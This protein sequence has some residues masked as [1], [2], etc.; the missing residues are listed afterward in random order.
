[1]LMIRI[2]RFPSY[3]AIEWILETGLK[4]EM[5]A[6]ACK[7][8]GR[9]AIEWILETG[10][11][12]IENFDANT[13]DDELQLSESWKRDWN[14][15]QRLRLFLVQWLQLSESWKRDWN[16]SLF[17]S[18]GVPCHVAIEWI[19]ETGLKRAGGLLIGGGGGA[20]QLSESWKRDWN[21]KKKNIQPEPDPLQLSES[22]K[23]D[24]NFEEL[25]CIPNLRNV[26][27]EWILE[28]GLKHL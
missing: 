19:L 26:A 3:V 22:W 28:T 14:L 2:Q 23:R 10:L 7:A 12:L 8:D 1:M 17:R 27:I 4:L 11:K 6:K 18:H 24:W 21:L 15:P 25:P 9:V 13:S 5:Y 20:L 16:L